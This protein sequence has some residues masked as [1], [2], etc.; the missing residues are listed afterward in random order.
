MI[1]LY[2]MLRNLLPFF[3]FFASYSSAQINTL[4][5]SRYTG[6]GS[7]IDQAEDMEVDAAGNT[8]VTGSSFNT[9]TGFDLTTVMYDPSG[10]EIW[11]SSFDGNNS[12]DQA[13]ALDYD[14][15]FVYVTG[16]V[17]Q[18]AAD[19]DVVVLKYVAATGALVWSREIDYQGYYDLGKDL[20]VDANGDVYFIGYGQYNSS[21]NDTDWLMGKISAAGT[22]LWTDFYSEDVGAPSELDE[23]TNLVLSGDKIY[24]SGLSAGISNNNNFDFVTMEYDTNQVAPAYNWRSRYDYNGNLD[25]PVDV[26]VDAGGNVYVAG[27]GYFNALQDVNYVLIKYNSAGTQQWVRTY[28]DST[29]ASDKD[30]LNDMSI[31]ASGNIYV[32]GSSIGNTSAE[33]FYTI[34]YDGNGNVLWNERYKTA[35]AAINEATGISIGGSG[36]VYIT[37]YSGIPGNGN[38]YTTLRYDANGTLIWFTHYDGT[39]N[40]SDKALA[41]YVDPTENIYVTGSS[42]GTGT[43][44]DYMTIKYCQLTTTASPDTSIC[45]GE[46]VLLD[47]VGAGGHSWSVVSGDPIVVGVNFSC[48][49][50]QDPIASPSVTTTYA[51]STTNGVGCTDFDT[52][53]VTVNPL[54]GPTITPDGPLN[55][56]IGDSVILVADSYPA[57]SWNTGSAN[58]SI[59]VYTSGTYEVTVEDAMGCLNTT[60]VSVTVYN[61]PLVDAGVSDSICP[62]D[63]TQL[64]ATGA[65]SYLWT[66]T[67]ELS[68]I[69]IDNPWA[70]PATSTY[71]S[72]TGEDINGCKNSDSVY[73]YVYP[74]PV[75]P[76]ITNII[77]NEQLVSSASN[78]NQW[79]LDNVIMTDST[80]QIL[81]YT[82]NGVYQILFTNAN[83]CSVWSDTIHVTNVDTSTTDTTGI[84]SFSI[85][86]LSMNLYPNPNNGLF[87]VDLSSINQQ[88]LAMH[89][90]SSTGKLIWR[91]EN[92]LVYGQQTIPVDMGD[93]SRG[94]YVMR[95]VNA[96]GES[97]SRSFVVQ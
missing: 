45:V 46:S 14:N 55:F 25:I 53:T 51:V 65:D 77:G 89:I 12:I 21:G 6:P 60:S 59:T 92:I 90:I 16:Y 35:G 81:N 80:D 74:A 83:G 30:N 76:T 17:H 94:M 23:G 3:V 66:Y 82:E 38:D 27:R 63:S 1:K 61:L 78:G 8:Y 34:K 87:T 69:I 47:A 54:P 57:Y 48:V 39:S 75:A 18:G 29:G 24:F 70:Y 31:D 85:E 62:G 42:T 5:E 72:V 71:Y 56:C 64:L 32:T 36:D 88:T 97:I 52:V 19:Y 44:Q 95:F 96:K 33:D 73:I 11:A 67:S 93:L 50:C 4:W 26:D 79:Y 49:N 41:I 2:I 13:Y 40:N 7:N 86:G 68:S 10:T 9:G 84:S 58:D 28:N 91:K 22:V 20:T 15:G 43:A 37:G